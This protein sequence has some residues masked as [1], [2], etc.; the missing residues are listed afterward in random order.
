[1]NI[2]P[3]TLRRLLILFACLGVVV[4]AGTVLALMY[5]HNQYAMVSRLRAEGFAA[6]DARDY[7]AA[8]RKLSEYFT[9]SHAQATDDE[10]L[11]RYGRARSIVPLEGLASRHIFEG[12]DAL[13]RYLN[14]RPDDPDDAKHLLLKLYAQVQYNKEAKTLAAKLLAKNPDDLEALRAQ[15]QAMNNDRDYAAAL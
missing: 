14:I 9:R 8:V 6:Y 13:E 11:F 12:I 5:R 15:A 2:R 3:K 4:V 1:M 10:A 7:D